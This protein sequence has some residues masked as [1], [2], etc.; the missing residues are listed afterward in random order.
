MTKFR[1]HQY[2]AVDGTAMHGGCGEPSFYIG[3]VRKIEI[4]ADGIVYFIQFAPGATWVQHQEAELFEAA[5]LVSPQ[6][7]ELIIREKPVNLAEYGK[8][9]WYIVRS[10]EGKPHAV[11]NSPFNTLR[12]A[13]E[14]VDDYSKLH[15]YKVNFW[16]M[17]WNGKEFSERMPA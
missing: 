2:V 5:V 12:G 1:L 17:Y 8:P 4:G 9:G 11:H 14:H 10:I 7:E 15:G 13:S 3:H 6:V 16:A